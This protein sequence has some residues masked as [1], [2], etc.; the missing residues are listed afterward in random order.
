MEG[1]SLAQELQD[2]LYSL[3]IFAVIVPLEM[4]LNKESRDSLKNRLI[5]LAYMVG[6]LFITL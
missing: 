1:I 2:A 5:N 4:Y 3:G 6:Y